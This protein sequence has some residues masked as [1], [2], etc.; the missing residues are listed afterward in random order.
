[1]CSRVAASKYAN[2]RYS[3]R[4][5]NR[6]NGQNLYGQIFLEKG[7]F[8]NMRWSCLLKSSKIALETPP[9]TG[10][11][12]QSWALKLRCA[13]LRLLRGAGEIIHF[14]CMFHFYT[15]SFGPDFNDFSKHDHLM[16]PNGPFSKK[17]WPFQLFKIGHIPLLWVLIFANSGSKNG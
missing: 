17:I 2:Y 3:I 16:L 8:G 9:P 13:H 15:H 1:M 10:I 5:K 6:K 11:T 14:Q 7:P 4:S 12:G